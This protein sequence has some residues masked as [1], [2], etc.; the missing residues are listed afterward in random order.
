[1]NEIENIYKKYEAAIVP[2]IP[3][4]VVPIAVSYK[5]GWLYYHDLPMAFFYLDFYEASLGVVISGLLF[6]FFT[7]GVAQQAKFIKSIGIGQ[8]Y[9]Y[10][11]WALM[12]I[13]VIMLAFV[14]ASLL[15]V[16]SIHFALFTLIG[17]LVN[18]FWTYYSD[19]AKEKKVSGS[20][21]DGVF[22]LS[23]EIEHTSEKKVANSEI[24]EVVL[25]V[26]C[27]A[28][29]VGANFANYNDHYVLATDHST[30]IIGKIDGY[31]IL[32]KEISNGYDQ[33]S[34]VNPV[35]VGKI[36]NKGDKISIS[37][38]IKSLKNQ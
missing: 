36:I 1:M 15:L 4:A 6:C 14:M 8:E 38:L 32:K 12:Q 5:L 11:K 7:V 9:K 18:M 13:L 21:W 17:F 31:V 35:E 24:L 2:S 37:A 20:F 34:L 3:F 19:G 10:I 27:F 22:S 23:K 25:L 28:F 33:V 26:F 16:V 30:H 29:V